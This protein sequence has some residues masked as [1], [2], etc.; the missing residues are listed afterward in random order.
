M[1]V[2][3]Q[4]RIFAAV[5]SEKRFGIYVFSPKGKELDYLKTPELPTNCCFGLGDDAGTLY[6]TVG[7]GFYKTATTTKGHHSAYAK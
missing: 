4:G 6:L 3:V 1:T 7:K 5:R 2:D